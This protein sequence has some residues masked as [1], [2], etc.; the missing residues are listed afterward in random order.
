[1]LGTFVG[2]LVGVFAFIQLCLYRRNKGFN[3]AGGYGKQDKAGVVGD[4]NSPAVFLGKEGQ[5][6]LRRRNDVHKVDVA[7][8][9]VQNSVDVN[10]KEHKS[11][12]EF[13]AMQIVLCG[14]GNLLG[15]K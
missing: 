5:A 2:R 14:K 11:K 6:V 9:V 12:Q 13:K 1:M 4:I 10:S 8:A 7:Y 15:G 3:V